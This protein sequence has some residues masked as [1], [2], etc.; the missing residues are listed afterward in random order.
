MVG[1]LTVAV[2]LLINLSLKPGTQRRRCASGRAG[3]FSSF[4]C[5]DDDDVDNDDDRGTTGF[6]DG[7]PPSR[8][9]AVIKT[10]K[11]HHKHNHSC[12]N[13]DIPLEKND[14]LT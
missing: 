1:S 14:Q 3:T 13:P 6:I 12:Q 9:R 8:L 10:Y 4:S 5:E 2:A 11:Q 7:P